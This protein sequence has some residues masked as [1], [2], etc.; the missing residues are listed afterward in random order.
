MTITPEIEE[1]IYKM[2]DRWVPDA[3]DRFLH[4]NPNTYMKEIVIKLIENNTI[5]P[6]L[7]AVQA[8][9]KNWGFFLYKRFGTLN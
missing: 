5:S 8:I 6:E 1:A 2:V 7:F 9:I 4:I 3:Q